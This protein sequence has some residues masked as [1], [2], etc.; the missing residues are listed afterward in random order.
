MERSPAKTRVTRPLG[1]HDLIVEFWL[2][3]RKPVV[4]K[5]ILREIQK[6]ISKHL[7][8]E[9]V[10]SPAAI[11]RV[12]ADEGAELR[13]PEVIEFDAAWRETRFEAEMTRFKGL[14]DLLIGRSL[15]LKGAEGQI[16]RLEELRLASVSS[17]TQ[18]ELRDVAILARQR[19]ESLTRDPAL[20][21]GQRDVQAEIVEWLKVWIETPNLFADW[22]ELRKRSTEFRENFASRED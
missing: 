16:K 4:G 11:A 9:Q 10:D 17:A 19:A 5:R 20:N 2:R 21:P 1:K 13:H 6:E 22:L 7:G 15:S 12:L 8:A 14:E 18:R 3:R